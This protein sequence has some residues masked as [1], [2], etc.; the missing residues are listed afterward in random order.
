MVRIVILGGGFGG[1]YTALGLQ[2]RL[3]RRRDVEITLI[4]GENY[5]L[6]YPLLP[7]AGMGDMEPDHPIIPIRS[8][9]RHFR[10]IRAEVTGVDPIRR[11]VLTA[12]DGVARIPYDHL[13]IAL[14]A[15]PNLGQ[16]CGAEETALT[17]QSLADAFY[18]R[19]HV[20]SCLE[21]AD[22][23]TDLER[24]RTLLTF[25]V[26][27]GGFTG[28]EVA[29]ELESFVRGI[30]PFYPRVDPRLF[31]FH[32]I[33]LTGQL[34]PE[35][36]PDLGRYACRALSERG[37]VVW[38]NTAT[39]HLAGD[40]IVLTD[41]H[42]LHARTTVVATGIRVP[43]LLIR[44]PWRKDAKGRLLVRPDLQVAEAPGVW[45]L[46]DCAALRDPAGGWY[47]ATAQHALREAD[48]LADNLKRSLDG[49]TTRPFHYTSRGTMVNLGRHQGVAKVLNWHLEGLPAWV[50]WRGYYLMRMPKWDRRLRV[51][52]DWLVRMVAPRDMSVLPVEPP[53]RLEHRA[54]GAP[55]HR[56]A[57]PPADHPA[58]TGSTANLERKTG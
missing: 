54:P 27:G 49:K 38:L 4:N 45:A 9:A 36:S 53:H 47:P 37:I 18:L 44:L 39:D 21:Q 28:V 33:Q 13:V 46:G 19:N 23:E 7:E 32:L 16:V 3:A 2:R 51:L 29:G 26:I 48:C 11:A 56:P 17:F 25:V 5:F 8:L 52:L 31:A 40:D 20:I 41:G 55:A 57:V 43:D 42:T 34:L 30:A 22:C 12:Q 58:A 50:L 14:G 24:Q 35:L 6:F 10:F 15:V 1:L